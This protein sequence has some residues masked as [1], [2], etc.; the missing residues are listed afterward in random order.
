MKLKPPAG[1]RSFFIDL[2]NK[3][4]YMG[5]CENGLI[6]IEYQQQQDSICEFWVA[7]NKINGIKNVLGMPRIL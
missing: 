5:E 2:S 4:C 1:S 3:G 7:W 6:G